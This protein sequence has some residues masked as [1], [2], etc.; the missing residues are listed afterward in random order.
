MLRGAGPVHHAELPH[1]PGCPANHTSINGALQGPG[2]DPGRPK[3]AVGA[4][5]R[6]GPAQPLARKRERGRRLR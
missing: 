1:P 5:R 6:S 3:Q 4:N 2:A